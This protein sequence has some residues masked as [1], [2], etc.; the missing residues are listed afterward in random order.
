ME[1]L[2]LYGLKN[3]VV[4]TEEGGG[5]LALKFRWR[6]FVGLGN[7]RLEFEEIKVWD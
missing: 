6:R 7:P 3:L 5:L 1:L 2:L 4:R